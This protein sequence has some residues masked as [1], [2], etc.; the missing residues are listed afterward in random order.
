MRLK[1]LKFAEQ[2]SV[3]YIYFLLKANLEIEG[4]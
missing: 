3:F 4:A 2:F 1:F